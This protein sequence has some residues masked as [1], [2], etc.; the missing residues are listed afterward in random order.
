MDGRS[1]EDENDL[2][3]HLDALRVLHRVSRELNATRDLSTTLQSVVDH[4]VS[5][6]GFGTAAINVVDGDVLAVAAVA[7]SD[8]ARLALS[9]QTGSL[10]AWRHLLTTAEP[11][12]SLRFLSHDA[13]ALPRDLPSWRDED[14]PVEATVPDAW[15]PDDALFAPLY[16]MLGELVGVL[17]VDMPINGRIPGMLQRELL[18]TF[19]AQAAIAVD[20]A[21]LHTELARL[22]AHDPLTGLA[23]HAELRRRLDQLVTEQAG[24]VV[25]YCDLD[26]FKLIN[27]TYGHQ[28]GDAVLIEVARRLV[29]HLGDQDTAARLGGDEFVLVMRGVGAGM[30]AD[31]AQ[32][33]AEDVGRP[34]DL[35][36]GGRQVV[37]GISVG[38]SDSVMAQ[39]TDQLLGLADQAMY[40]VKAT[41]HTRVNG[42]LGVPHTFREA[43]TAED[44]P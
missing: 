20:N 30:A 28:A 6:L 3:E 42:H 17:S 11:W 41:S 18:E 26:R 40:R 44:A 34:V 35:P 33:V 7:G 9:G 15:H 37:V 14:A 8:E 32:R 1:N 31:M 25:F 16:S 21:H 19:A 27:D 12:G 22:A 10:E 38:Y 4:V 2:L 36:A 29:D 43:D 24:V 13:A 23:N 39:T 5:S